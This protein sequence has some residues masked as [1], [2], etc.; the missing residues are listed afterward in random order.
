MEQDNNYYDWLWN[1]IDRLWN[2]NE[3]QALIN[4][5]EEAKNN[6]RY[7]YYYYYIIGALIRL[8]RYD[9]A[10]KY[11]DS[12][13]LVF[14]KEDSNNENFADIRYRFLL[15][16]SELLVPYGRFYEIAENSDLIKQYIESYFPTDA[17]NIQFYAEDR[18]YWYNEYI[19]NFFNEDYNNRKVITIAKTD[20]LFKSDHITLL[21]M[22]NLPAVNF[23]ITHPK[24]DHTYVCHPYKTDTY[25]PIEEYDYE[26]LNDR[27]NEFCY[28]LQCLG[29]TSIYIENTKGESNNNNAYS[30]TQANIEASIRIQSGGA[31]I[32][33]EYKG[34]NYNKS[35]L[36]IGR[37]Q[38]FNPIKPP[39]IPEGL[40]WFS[41][42]AGW[43]RLV[44]QRLEG[45]L[46]NHSEYMS[47]TE[48]KILS[49]AEISDIN[50][51]LNLL[52]ATI[53]GGRR[54][55]TNSN[56][57]TNKEVEWRIN[58][59]FK[60]IEQFGNDNYI[61]SEDKNYTIETPSIIESSIHKGDFT[62]EEIQYMDE[63]KFMLED[64]AAIDDQERRMLNEMQKTLG[65][66]AEHA[67]KLEEEAINAVFSFSP[68]EQKYIEEI[69][70]MLEDDGVIDDKERR[71][72]N[73][74]LDV[75]NI[76]H[77]R[78]RQLE[79]IVLNKG[80][81]TKEEKE[82]LVKAKSFISDGA[83][84]D[85]ERRMLNRLANLLGISEQRAVEL[86][87]QL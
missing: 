2:N 12:F 7:D 34:S 26:L 85:R 52:F 67:Q 9:E 29:A 62:S 22:S 61:V 5:V 4:L 35:T 54:N 25:L 30:N 64:D 70:F 27:I 75:L 33:E 58:V 6:I 63:V 84:S 11:Y 49:N 55:E 81:L 44:Q 32:E 8:E 45:S 43:H 24:Q 10:K 13:R 42:E 74:M 80:D 39:F 36:K 47:S 76:S 37:E 1:E 14:E 83:I 59:T 46:L 57:E 53:K 78:A 72:L 21:Q 41:H 65:I 56:I 48:H 40:I 17:E 38:Q 73:N 69:K 77:E 50:G 66:P 16:E 79:V 68:N 23:P 71:I 28:L 86:E 31:R 19:T 87:N 3:F 82:Y 51:E 60:P 20:N 15:T 18:N